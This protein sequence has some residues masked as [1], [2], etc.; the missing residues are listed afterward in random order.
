M[1]YL[2]E[3]LITPAAPAPTA[4]CGKGSPMTLRTGLIPLSDFT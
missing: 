4:H 1:T 2:M 3:Q